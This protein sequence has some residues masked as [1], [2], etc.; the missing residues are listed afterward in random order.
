MT[1]IKPVNKYK[2]EIKE[3]EDKP[4]ILTWYDSSKK[5]TISPVNE[6]TGKNALAEESSVDAIAEIMARQLADYKFAP[7]DNS[8]YT[9]AVTYVTAR[10]GVFRVVKTD[11]AL[12]KTL[13]KAIENDITGLPK[14]EEGVELLIPKL[15]FRYILQ[16]LT[17]FKDVL[18]QDKTESSLLFFWNKDNK[19]LPDTKGIYQ[20]GQLV[21]YC[22]KQV[23]QHALTDFG[24]DP[25]I[26][27]LRS[28]M[29]LLLELH[30][31][32]DFSAFFSGTDDANENMNQFY[33][34]WG[35]CHLDTPMF[36][37]RWVSGDVKRE[38]S[39]DILI[40]WPTVTYKE[41]TQTRLMAEITLND[42]KGYI[43]TKDLDLEPTDIQAP[44]NYWE[45]TE[46]VKG[47]FIEIDYPI[48]W[49][50]EQHSKYTYVSPYYNTYNQKNTKPIN[51]INKYK[52][53]TTGNATKL[54]TQTYKNDKWSDFDDAYNYNGSY[55]GYSNSYYD[56]DDEIYFEGYE[57]GYKEGY[58]IA[59]IE[60]QEKVR[61]E[62]LTS[63]YI[64]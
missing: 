15:D 4:G 24:A 55:Y 59:A 37:F 7:V 11:V 48:E 28:N 61:T 36:A 20:E 29:G 13:Y 19:P 33:G 51:N 46:L 10:N 47:P 58:E 17:F 21:V 56:Y 35:N 16:A 22:P 27:W 23:N 43:N 3:I 26:D 63:K 54:S 57:V 25:H 42:T 53:K 32:A 52:D 5:E 2:D 40:D 64:K 1:N 34:V 6:S 41:T 50:T 62:Y 44:D 8:E 38:C 18:A 31:H 60:Y 12:F 45:E 30:S 49:L 9:K 39:P 14:M